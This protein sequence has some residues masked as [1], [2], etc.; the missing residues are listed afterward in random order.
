MATLH[1]AEG[2]RLRTVRLGSG[3]ITYRRKRMS[4]VAIMVSQGADAIPDSDL[5]LL[6]KGKQRL[7]F[8]AEWW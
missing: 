8:W 1:V 5:V 7:F 6:A 2:G 3:R 4:N